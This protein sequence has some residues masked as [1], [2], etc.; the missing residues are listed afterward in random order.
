MAQPVT[1]EI[2]VLESLDAA[3]HEAARFILLSVRESVLCTGRCTLALAGGG[4]PRRLYQLLASDEY[5]EALP[6]EEIT[7]FWSDE[8][9]VPPADSRSNFR[10]AH[11][12]M[13][14]RVATL[15]SQMFRMHGELD[16]PRAAMSYETIIREEL[17]DLAFDLILLGVGEDGHTASLFP[18]HPA[19]EE[20]ERLVMA[21]DGG[22]D[23]DVRE[24]ITM[25]L[26]L[27]NRARSVLVL[28]AGASKRPVVR[29]V[30][31]DPVAA[32]ERYPVAR[33][34]P[35]GHLTWIVDQAAGG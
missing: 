8:R 35:A 23:L 14:S 6:W 9:C 25:T 15:P 1:P 26:P 7:W 30:Q 4:T 12:A 18:G 20:R 16:P 27:I 19:L 17:P 2:S 11:E 29:A 3:S 28:A 10:M 5:R 34:R 31:E 32:A 24:R 21:V 13:L 22:P 33:L